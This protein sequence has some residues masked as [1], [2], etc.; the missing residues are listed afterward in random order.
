M[1]D[2]FISRNSYP[3]FEKADVSNPDTAPTPT[4][5]KAEK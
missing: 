2:D 1:E 5:I 4:P 3:K